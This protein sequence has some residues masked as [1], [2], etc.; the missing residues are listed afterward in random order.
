MTR[1]IWYSLFCLSAAILYFFLNPE[2]DLMVS[3]Y[4]Y[5]GSF[6]D[7]SVFPYNVLYISGKVIVYAVSFAF[8]GLF[9]LNFFKSKNYFGI[10]NSQIAYICFSALTGP[11]LIIHGIFKVYFPRAR[12]VQ[13]VQFGGDHQFTPVFHKSFSCQDCMSFASGHAA[14]AFFLTAFLFIV[15]EKYRNM[16]A[17]IILPYA[18]LVSYSRIVNGGHFLSDVVIGALTAI[19]INFFLAGIFLEDWH[20]EDKYLM[21]FSKF[22]DNLSFKPNTKSRI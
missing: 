14:G 18:F 7:K 8:V 3:K 13:I 20:K 15:P 10:K 19:F 12:P 22:I 11:L 21:R 5:N 4:Y 6:I 16:L 2:V 17:A 1:C 9:I